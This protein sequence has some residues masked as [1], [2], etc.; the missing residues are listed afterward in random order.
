MRAI[1]L[2]YHGVVEASERRRI[3]DDVRSLSLEFVD[4]FGDQ[5]IHGCSLAVAK[6]QKLK[7]PRRRALSVPAAALEAS[8]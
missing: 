6:D 1:S 2:M 5:G 3:D 8:R 7:S 4:D